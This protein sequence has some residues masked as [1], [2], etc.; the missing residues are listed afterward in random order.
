MQRPAVAPL[1]L[2]NEHGG[3]GFLLEPV[4][5]GLLVAPSQAGSLIG[6]AA[7]FAFLMRHPLRLA[8][9]DLLR[10]RVYPRTRVCLLLAAAYGAVAAAAIGGAA[11]T[12]PWRAL[13]P[14]AG[15]AA[16]F[17][18]QFAFD[19]RNRTRELTPEIAGALAGATVAAAIALAG[20]SANAIALAVAVLSASRAVPSILFIRA[21]LRGGG[22]AVSLALHV[23]AIGIAA[24]LWSAGAAPAIAIA[25]MVLLLIRA[26]ATRPN[27]PAKTIGIRELAWGAAVV[28][29]IGLAY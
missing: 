17:A 9:S 28:L 24:A 23:A 1:A 27:T 5:L 4:V 26:I 20:G 6:L 18:V 7:L 19:A 22:H 15:G 29:A 21:A 12:G 11:M 14:L 25:A 3:W 16:A 10:R 8:A 2:P 13:L